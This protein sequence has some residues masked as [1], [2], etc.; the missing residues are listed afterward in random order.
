MQ[1]KL[2]E[3]TVIIDQVTARYA[4]GSNCE[5]KIETMKSRIGEL[6][7]KLLHWKTELKQ[8]N[9]GE[10][11]KAFKKKIIGLESHHLTISTAKF[12]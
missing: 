9:Y 2:T 10:T 8:V 1:K 12:S 6:K 11:I 3:V 5:T 4:Q 7:A